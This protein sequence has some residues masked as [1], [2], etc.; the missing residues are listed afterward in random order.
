M[1]I[2]ALHTN[3]GSRFY[4]VVPQLKWMQKQG[5]E[6]RLEKHDTKH[7]DE[8]LDW[9]DVL[10]LQMVFSREIVQEAKKKGKKVVFECDDLIHKT[11]EKHYAWKET[12]GIK[13]QL[14]WWW[15]MYR[16]IGICD[17]FIVSND[18][19]RKVYGWMCKKTF[20]FPNYL[21]LEHWMK[22]P[23]KNPTDRIRILWAGSS[24]HTGDLEW[25]KPIIGKILAKYANV[26]FIYVGHGG[27]PTDDLYARFVYGED[28]FEGIPRER[29]ESLLP[30]PANV[31][32][33]ILGSI[34]ADIAIA[35]LE[36][37]Y[38]N[39]FKTQC[40]YYEYGINGIP[41]VYSK[42]FY[43]EVRDNISYREPTGDVVFDTKQYWNLRM[44][45]Q[46]APAGLTSGLLA[47]TPDEWIS[48]LSLLIENATLR[49]K[50]GENARKAILRDYN[51]ADHAKEW[52]G[53][54]ESLYK[55]YDN[56]TNPA[57]GITKKI[58]S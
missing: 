29:R 51:F 7:F 49:T 38:F 19:L 1:K 52:Q 13:N 37:N 9:C 57:I 54:V 43:T 33:Y 23:K 26:Q 11:H 46:I 8:L 4:R 16:T 5:H 6:V 24:S 2:L 21:E 48:A 30:A 14:R 28:I 41:A 47:D 31:W 39:S 40:K 35:P 58:G 18:S 36:K 3:A 25:V 55:D 12:Q 10:I 53:F 34:Q 15:R 27:V 32:P 56:R 17:G 50:I 42:W 44:M 22:E 20:V 45:S